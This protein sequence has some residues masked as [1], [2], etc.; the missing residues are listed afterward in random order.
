MKL[1]RNPVFATILTIVLVIGSTL[2]NTR[3]KFG[4]LCREASD[5]FFADQGIA[6]GLESICVDASAVASLAEE[7]GLD[8]SSLRGALERLREDLKDA[9]P[10]AELHQ[11]YMDLRSELSSINAKFMVNGLSE[12]DSQAVRHL[13]DSIDAANDKLPDAAYNA[14]VQAFLEKYDRF[15][16]RFLAKLAGVKMPEVF[17]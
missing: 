1:F 3:V 8:A 9:R 10:A 15:P 16:T 17:A 5:D 11:D 4:K 12:K 7:K 14:S 6:E 2:L 13:L